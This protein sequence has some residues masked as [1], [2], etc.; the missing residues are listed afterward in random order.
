MEIIPRKQNLAKQDFPPA[1]EHF[2]DIFHFC[3]NA[4]IVFY[5]IE[6]SIG[7]PIK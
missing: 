1:A 2:S 3:R 4:I 6:N 5:L 7:F